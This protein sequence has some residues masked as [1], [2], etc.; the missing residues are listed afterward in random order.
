MNDIEKMVIEE[1]RLIR[2][3]INEIKTGMSK[4][5]INVA[6]F[7]TFFGLIGAYIKSKFFL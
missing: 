2:S 1:L 5:K 6:A 4:I 3:D 7:A